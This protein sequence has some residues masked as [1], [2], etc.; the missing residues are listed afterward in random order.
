MVGILVSSGDGLCS[1]AM[2]VSG[3]VRL[4]IVDVCGC[5]IDIYFFLNL[6]LTKFRKSSMIHAGKNNWNVGRTTFRTCVGFR[7][8]QRCPLVRFKKTIWLKSRCN[9]W[10]NF[11][12]DLQ[13]FAEMHHWRRSQLPPDDSE[14]ETSLLSSW[15]ASILLRKIVFQPHFQ[16]LCQLLC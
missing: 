2:L 6:H 15:D 13:D 10:C 9:C 7:S 8:P 4:Q 14:N 16:V 12:W 1:G 5:S 3:R 11:G